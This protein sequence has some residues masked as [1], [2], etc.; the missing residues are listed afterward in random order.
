MFSF[1]EIGQS[2]LG[3]K[4]YTDFSVVQGKTYYYRIR[5]TDGMG[6]Y[7]GYS[8]ILSASTPSQSIV[9]TASSGVNVTSLSWARDPVSLTST[10]IERSIN[11]GAFSLLAATAATATSY[12]DQTV[13]PGNSYGYRVKFYDGRGG[14]SVDSNSVS[15]SPTGSN[16]V[17]SVTNVQYS[18]AALLT[19]S[20]SNTS[21]VTVQVEKSTDGVNFASL[22]T[23]TNTFY[24]DSEV[25]SGRSYGYR[26]RW[27]V[28]GMYTPYS[29]ATWLSPSSG[30][31]PVLGVNGL[32]TVSAA[33]SSW[34]PIPNPSIFQNGVVEVK[35]PGQSV[36]K[37]V[38]STT[39]V[40]AIHAG[41]VS[42]TSYVYR[43][44]FA[45][46]SNTGASAYSSEVT[47]TT[48]APVLTASD[49]GTGG[50]NLNITGSTSP[51]F[52]IFRSTDGINF[53]NNF[54]NSTK[55]FISTTSYTDSSATGGVTYYYYVKSWDG[56]IASN[57]VSIQPQ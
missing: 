30:T 51:Y 53:T 33:G 35:E 7:A 48:P 1:A 16:P 43:V 57:I 52:M 5:F 49:N 28:G 34:S 6:K 14:F 17:L 27:T 54:I 9:L 2:G 24:V 10:L 11:G 4:G 26:I 18:S 56:G 41:L 55:Q 32:G 3:D 13:L 45:N 44:K 8:S 42:G 47:F 39:R 20:P 31:T 37:T 23:T 15:A 46:S 38:T 40:A 12:T 22:G 25:T 50:V 19:W 21:G 29:Q 36:F